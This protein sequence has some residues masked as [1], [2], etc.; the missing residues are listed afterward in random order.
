MQNRLTVKKENTCKYFNNN[1]FFKTLLSTN[2]KL[3]IN[4]VNLLARVQ[5][6]T[7]IAL[8]TRV[9]GVNREHQ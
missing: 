3:T 8:N 4:Y 5:L 7:I 1:R 6:D 9:I 2:I